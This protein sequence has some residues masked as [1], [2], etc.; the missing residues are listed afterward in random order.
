M[1]NCGACL[2]EDWSLEIGEVEK[3]GLV[4]PYHE[5]KIIADGIHY[6]ITPNLH[7]LFVVCGELIHTLVLGDG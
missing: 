7:I 2:E 1:V 3:L 6:L 5:C 4:P